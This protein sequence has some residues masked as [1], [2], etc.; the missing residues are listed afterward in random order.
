MTIRCLL[1]ASWCRI[2]ATHVPKVALLQTQE[3]R[4]LV[5][6]TQTKDSNRD[7]LCKSHREHLRRLRSS[8]PCNHRSCTKPHDLRRETAGIDPETVATV[9]RGAL[10]NAQTALSPGDYITTNP[11][12]AR[13]YAGTGTVIT[14]D[15]LAKEILDDLDEPLSE[16]SIYRP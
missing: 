4:K 6:T 3:R 14:Q 16:D 9:Y 15:V 8:Q 7:E 5:S 2:R 12:L 10:A 1:P 13:D 11:Q